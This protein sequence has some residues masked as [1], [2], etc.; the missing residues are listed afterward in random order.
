MALAMD[1]IT[2]NAEID[3]L[4]QWPHNGLAFCWG[5]SGGWKGV[6]DT[7]QDGGGLRLSY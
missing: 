4:Y 3:Q 6:L 7:F 1:G 5:E 2:P